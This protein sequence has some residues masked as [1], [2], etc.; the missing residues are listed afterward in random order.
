M[1][2]RLK[3]LS[4]LIVSFVAALAVSSVVF[5][6]V[7]KASALELLHAQIAVLRAQA[8]AV[9]SYTSDEIKPLLSDMSNVQFLPQIVP[10]FSAQSTFSKF[11]DQFPDFYYKEAA[12]NPTNPSDAA[13]P[14]ETDM[15]NLL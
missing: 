10:S 1:G 15:I 6:R 11:R 13:T 2:L 7:S 12:L 3:F 14:W 4:I 8:L 5:Y 9:R